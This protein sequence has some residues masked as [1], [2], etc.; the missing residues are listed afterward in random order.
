MSD[1]RLVYTTDDKL[2]HVNMEVFD[3]VQACEAR[4][5]YVERVIFLNKMKKRYPIKDLIS[6]RKKRRGKMVSTS[7]MR[8][9][10]ERVIFLLMGNSFTTQ[11]IAEEMKKLFN[12][13]IKETAITSIILKTKKWTKIPIVAKKGV[14][15]ISLTEYGISSTYSYKDVVEKYLENS[16][17]ESA[18]NAEKYKR[19]TIDK[20]LD[21]RKKEQIE[22]TK[23]EYDMKSKIGKII[24]DGFEKI[25]VELSGSIDVNININ[26]NVR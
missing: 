8:F 18:E 13:H 10:Y 1:T 5:D 23:A 6:T 7:N 16:K 21:K 19:S 26:F 25:G 11:Q 2:K 3:E 14:K 17:K 15:G 20:V 9:N 4:N 22:Q 24:K 12:V